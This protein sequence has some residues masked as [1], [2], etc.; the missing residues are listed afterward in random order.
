VAEIIVAVGAIISEIP[1][2]D[3]LEKKGFKLIKNGS[4]VLVDGN[5]GVVEVMK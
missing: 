1:M 3:K 5:K 2:V 4:K